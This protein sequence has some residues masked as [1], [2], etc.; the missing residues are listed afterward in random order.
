MRRVVPVLVL[1]LLVAALFWLPKADPVR[2]AALR[3]PDLLQVPMPAAAGGTLADAVLDGT[4]VRRG[5]N[6]NLIL[7]LGGVRLLSSTF[8][9]DDLT[10]H[11]TARQALIS[12]LRQRAQERGETLEVDGEL[13]PSPGGL[14]VLFRLD[15]RGYSFESKGAD[16]SQ[17]NATL[18]G[19]TPPERSSL[20]PPL[21]AIAL[22]LLFRPAILALFMGAWAASLLLR[23]GAPEG[24][25]LGSLALSLPDLGT[26]LLRPQLT[27][28]RRWQILGFLCATL[29]MFAVMTRAGGMRGLMHGLAR[30]AHDAR[31]TQLVTWLLG[32]LLGFDARASC[33]LTGATM[34]P[35]SD[36]MRVSR[37]KL[38]YLVNSTAVPVAGLSI[39]GTWMAFEVASFSA[40]LPAADLPS[41]AGFGL[42]LETLPFRLYCILSL[43]LSGAIVLSGRDFGPMLTA[44]R[45]ARLIGGVLGRGSLPMVSAAG[46][47][48]EL[49][50]GALPRARNAVLPLLVC[51]AVT[52]LETLRVGLADMG[53]SDPRSGV[54]VL[55][56]LEGFGAVLGRGDVTRALL[57]GSAAGLAVAVLL[58]AS[59]GLRADIPRA[60]GTSLRSLGVAVAILYLAWMLATACE[61]LGTAHYLTALVGD[62][63]APE[64]LPAVVFLVGG[65]VAFATG[66]AWSTM[67]I[68]MPLVVALAFDLGQRSELGGRM[69]MV[70]TIAAVLEGAI[71][72]SHAS[73]IADTTVLSS[74]SS[75]SDHMD[76]VRTQLPYA[77]TAMLSAL[78]VG[79]LP[80]T[81]MG[82]HPG[83]ALALAAALMLTVLF[84]FGRKS[85]PAARAPVVGI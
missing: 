80:C 20:L 67:G 35:W 7:W 57:V 72:G 21:I 13:L 60:I 2:V 10:V 11:G 8:V 47:G 82:Q 5:D 27:D 1:G 69:L 23:L 24:S 76:H 59:S 6:G 12:G 71:F 85:E 81:F 19:W 38:A 52:L 34:R 39:L 41:S 30:R 50:P 43:V 84:V 36:R 75:A 37:E 51:V 49:H 26:R 61:L 14:G 25:V 73:P 45:R 83:L 65:A 63:L 68:L 53:A 15:E 77:L 58:A 66:S 18:E 17:T 62:H 33:V 16:G 9:T 78:G 46:S 22:A 74:T 79:F 42:L 4:S 70:I 3:V 56:T 44:E 40:H 29:A 48:L 32:I 31:R 64:I 55:F 28:V 54:A